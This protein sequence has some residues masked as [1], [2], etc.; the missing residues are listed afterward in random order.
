[1]NAGYEPKVGNLVETTP[2]GMLEGF[3]EDERE[4]LAEGFVLC[5]TSSNLN[6]RETCMT[7]SAPTTLSMSGI[8]ETAPLYRSA[9]ALLDNC[10]VGI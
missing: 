4:V 3:T 1:M 2:S 6:F 8:C 10:P 7:L 5:L 9:R